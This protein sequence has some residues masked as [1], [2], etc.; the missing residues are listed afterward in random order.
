MC[1]KIIFS[2]CLF[3]SI[4]NSGLHATG[5]IQ[6]Q[7]ER[8]GNIKNFLRDYLEIELND[9]SKIQFY[10]AGPDK[11]IFGPKANFRVFINDKIT[12]VINQDGSEVYSFVNA[13]EKKITEETKS[14]TT[15]EAF[16]KIKKLLKLYKLPE[17]MSQYSI[18]TESEYYSIQS[19]NIE[20]ENIPCRGSGFFCK[21]FRQDGSIYQ[22][23]YKP[24][25]LPI[26]KKPPRYKWNREEL[27]TIKEQLSSQ[28]YFKHH[29]FT[30]IEKEPTLVIAP[31]LNIFSSQIE[32]EFMKKVEYFYVWEIEIRITERAG[33]SDGLIWIDP[34]SKKII[35]AGAKQ[36]YWLH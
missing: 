33:D 4:F 18:K 23:T 1:N 11:S 12:L 3:L 26:N 22:F 13:N 2:L 29:T 30:I 10:D 35:G 15:V 36:V 9:E 25:Y 20:I 21:L 7:E 14:I 31:N 28:D 17:D 32:Q 6:G 16:N 27:E 24:A 19:G 5:E 8:K 34:E